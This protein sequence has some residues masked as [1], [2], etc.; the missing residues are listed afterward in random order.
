METAD[1]TSQQESVARAT[2]IPQI[3]PGPS[4]NG[5]PVWVE[6]DLDFIQTLTERG[7]DTFKKCFQCGTCSATCSLSPDMEPFPRK[8]MIWASWGMKDRLL[9]DPDVWL[10]HQ[11]NDCSIRCPRGARPGDVLAVVRRESVLHYSTPRFLGAWVRHPK[12]VPIMLLVPAALLGLAL[13]ARDPVERALGIS[14]NIGEEIVFSYSSWFPHWLLNS[15]FGFFGLLALLAMVVGVTRFWRTIKTA[16]VRVGLTTPVKG[17]FPSIVSALKNIIAHKQFDTCTSAHSRYLSHLL[18]FFGFIALTL[19]T[20]WVIT[21][22]YNPLIQGHF[23]YPFGFWYPWKILANLGGVAIVIGCI[24]MIRQRLMDSEHVGPGTYFDWAFMLSLL[25]VVV[26]GFATE[27]MHYVRLEPHRHVAYFVHLVF[28]FG[29]LI[30][31]PYSKFAHLVYRATAMVFAEYSGINLGASHAETDRVNEE[32]GAAREARQVQA[33]QVE[34][35][36]D[37]VKSNQ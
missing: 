30:Y 5:E 28:V 7:G 17:L 18:V 25:I 8:E 20:L 36:D 33:D 31:L 21:A 1:E 14:K 15:F 2:D 13:L 37:A 27:V 16:G 35:R 34:E 23:V 4:K 10:C 3:T 32:R 9:T 24:T 29:L 6:S 12:Y 26:T 22:R 11:C 19:V